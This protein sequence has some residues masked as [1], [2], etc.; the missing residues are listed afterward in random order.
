MKSSEGELSMKIKDSLVV[1]Q[2]AGQTVIMDMSGIETED[3]MVTTNKTGAF[4]LEMLKQE[5][6]REE[7]VAALLD[8]YAVTE[9]TAKEHVRLF[10]E[11]LE[12]LGFLDK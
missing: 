8:K 9:E 7:L 6:T 1:S 3:K 11:G 5:H 4:L 2:V 10:V 12:E